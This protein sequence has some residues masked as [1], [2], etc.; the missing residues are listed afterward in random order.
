MLFPVMSLNFHMFQWILQ[1]HIKWFLSIRPSSSDWVNSLPYSLCFYTTCLIS[2]YYYP[3]IAIQS[4][5]KK[6]IHVPE[7]VTIVL[8]LQKGGYAVYILLLIPVIEDREKMCSVK[9]YEVHTKKA[10]KKSLVCMLEFGGLLSVAKLR[11]VGRYF[12]C[13]KH[14][15]FLG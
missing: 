7:G 6:S 15:T 12:P 10:E 13:M 9:W 1:I 5:M 3:W 11:E 14:C 8:L 4:W 2:L